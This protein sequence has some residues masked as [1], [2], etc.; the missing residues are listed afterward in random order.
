[1]RRFFSHQPASEEVTSKLLP[2]F[3]SHRQPEMRVEPAMPTID[4][5]KKTLCKQGPEAAIDFF[6][7]ESVPAGSLCLRM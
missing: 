5:L 6:D 3:T 4:F 7:E 1:M 2:D